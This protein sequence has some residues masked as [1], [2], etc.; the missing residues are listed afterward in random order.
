MTARSPISDLCLHLSLISLLAIGGANSVVPEIYRFVVDARHIMNASEFSEW[1]A[2]A[3][4]APGPNVLLVALIGWKLAGALGALLA[5]TAICAPTCL[6]TY[7][8]SRA[9]D[10]HRGKSALA[11]F[12]SAVAPLSTGLVLSSGYLLSRGSGTRAGYA[13]TLAAALVAFTSRRNPPWILTAGAALGVIAFR[14]F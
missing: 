9:W 5:L 12:L 8:V 11:L 13:I 6:L 1:Y 10:K 4:A 3:Q 14:T 7:W 2:L